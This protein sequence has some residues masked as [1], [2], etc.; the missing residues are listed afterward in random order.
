MSPLKLN[1]KSVKKRK[2]VKRKAAKKIIIRK[3]LPTAKTKLI[4][5]GKISHYYPKVNAAVIKLK[6]PLKIGD[7]IKIEG[8]NIQFKQKVSSIQIDR[9]P[10]QNAKKGQEIGLE[11]IKPVKDNYK[12]YK[13]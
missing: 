6:S 1:S 4:L 7:S 5:L 13:T 10:I 8:K 9:K 3:T 2:P 12:I 11:V